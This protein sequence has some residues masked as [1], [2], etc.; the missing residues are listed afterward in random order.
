MKKETLAD[1]RK[2]LF[3]FMDTHILEAYRLK[4]NPL[5]IIEEIAELIKKQDREAVE[6]LREK[7]FWVGVHQFI[8]LEDLDELVR[9]L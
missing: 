4:Q 9:E 2:E 6:R 7:A 8:K 1:K 3:E 5:I